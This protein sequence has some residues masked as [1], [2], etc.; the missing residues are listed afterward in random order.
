MSVTLSIIVAIAN[1]NAIGKD[2]Q[3]LWHLPEDLQYFKR[4]TMGKPIVM[5]R[6]TFESIGRP[7]P[8]RLNIVITRQQDW[9]HDGVK[10][11]HTI[12]DALRLAE[13]QSMIDGINEMMVIGG[14]EIYKTALSQAD[15]LYVTRVD[16]VID[17]DAFFPEIDQTVWQETHRE[18]HTAS[19]STLKTNTYDYAFCELEK[20]K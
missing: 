10:V 18:N 12:N 5:G 20:R 9:Q 19:D 16:A 8:G 15:K 1:N 4:T 11:V 13:A 3:L 14:A 17:G 7:L 2:N 6:K